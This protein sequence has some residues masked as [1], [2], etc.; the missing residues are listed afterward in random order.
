MSVALP[1]ST[2]PRALRLKRWGYLCFLLLPALPLTGWWLGRLAGLPDLFAWWTPFVSFGLVPLADAL[3][4]TDLSSPDD[5]QS[6][7]LESDPWYRALPLLALPVCAALLAWGLWAL[8][9]TPL[10]WAGRIGHVVSLGVV[11]GAL[12]ITAAHEL[13]H[14]AERLDQRAGGWLLALACYGSF[15]IEHLRGHHVNVATPLDTSS[16]ARGQSLYHFLPRAVAGNVRAAWG[17]EA[18]RLRREGRAVL[19]R[20]NEVLRLTLLSASLAALAGLAF[21]PTGLIGFL[22]QAALAIC[23]LEII[24]YVEHYGL[25]RERLPDGRWERTGPRHSWNA[26][27]LFTNLLLFQLQR[28]SDHHAH[29]RR[30][31]SALRHHPDVPT[32]PAG[33]AA[34]VLLALMPPLWFRVMHRRL[35]PWQQSTAG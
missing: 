31:Y 14:K 6:R 23:L 26:P 18:Q 34:M 19:S 7:A 27:H 33:Y 21:G 2:G 4:G 15:K 20:H 25:R 28:H 9:H 12:G 10:G 29:A 5:A 3:I 17:L 22:G 30:R 13:I 1:A 16:A 24:N 35:A 11:T 32:L 8:A